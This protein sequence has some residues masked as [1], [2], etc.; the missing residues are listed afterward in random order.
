MI[1]AGVGENSP[2]GDTYARTNNVWASIF[3]FGIGTQSHLVNDCLLDTGG[4]VKGWSYCSEEIPSK[5]SEDHYENI[6]LPPA[7][8]RGVGVEQSPI[9]FTGPF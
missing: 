4:L 5:I 6:D 8:L 7:Q 9:T 2:F 3:P 1:E